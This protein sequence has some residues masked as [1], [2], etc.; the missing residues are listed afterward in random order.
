MPYG[1]Q[2]IFVRADL[3]RCIVTQHSAYPLAPLTTLVSEAQI[4]TSTVGLSTVS[5]AQVVKAAYS[6]PNMHAFEHMHT[7]AKHTWAVVG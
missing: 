1:D 6:L 4:Y 2:A 7:L 3:L 5:E